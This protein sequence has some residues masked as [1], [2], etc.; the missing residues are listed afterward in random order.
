LARLRGCLRPRRDE[1]QRERL[2]VQEV[3]VPRRLHAELV[4]REVEVARIEVRHGTDQHGAVGVVEQLGQPHLRRRLVLG[5]D[6]FLVV[7]QLEGVLVGAVGGVR[8]EVATLLLAAV[9]EAHDPGH[10]GELVP[11]VVETGRLRVDEH[12]PGASRGVG[13]CLGRVAGHPLLI[14]RLGH[15]RIGRGGFGRHGG[16]G[17]RPVGCRDAS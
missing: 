15:G 3:V 12:E 1:R 5:R 13:A 6:A 9:L 7:G 8:R 14:P 17:G 11:A 10:L 2:D 16:S 4:T